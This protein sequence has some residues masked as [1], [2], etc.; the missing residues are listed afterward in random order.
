MDD[1]LMGLLLHLASEAEVNQR[2]PV[3][4]P[5]DGHYDSTVDESQ[6]S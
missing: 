3:H 1:E 2:P 6:L 4:H 5:L